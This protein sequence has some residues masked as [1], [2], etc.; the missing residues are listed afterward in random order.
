MGLPRMTAP[1]SPQPRQQSD[2]ALRPLELR[3]VQQLAALERD[4]FPELWPPTAFGREAKSASARYL[5]AWEPAP[6]P[7]DALPPTPTK[8]LPLWKRGLYWLLGVA[9]QQTAPA[10]V[11]AHGQHVVGYVGT[12]SM[13]DEA[14]IISVGVLSTHRRRGVGELLLLGALELALRHGSRVATLEVRES[15]RAAQNLYAKYGF[16]VAGQRKRYYADNGEDAL[17]M[18]TG[19]LSTP[20]YQQRLRALAHAHD[21]RWGARPRV[22]TSP[23]GAA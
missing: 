6:P 14:H 1:S 2:F 18:T 12:W 23:S 7:A 10:N 9:D 21:E 13:T 19:S 15:N 8:R 5:V 4:A 17:I 3:D 20:E 11:A 22:L 16:A